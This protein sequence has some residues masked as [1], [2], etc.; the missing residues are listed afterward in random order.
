MHP[1]L[2]N[3][4]AKLDASNCLFCKCGA[5]LAVTHNGRNIGLL[6]IQAVMEEES[7]C[8]GSTVKL[9]NVRKKPGALFA[10]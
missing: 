6:G 1:K 4:P 5:P 7:K 10:K 3:L 9:V 8:P 2:P